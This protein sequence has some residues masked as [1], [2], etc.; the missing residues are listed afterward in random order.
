M[1]VSHIWLYSEKIKIQDWR[2]NICEVFARKP[3]FRPSAS[4]YDAI[5]KGLQ[6]GRYSCPEQRSTNAINLVGQSFY[7]MTCWPFNY[8]SNRDATL[9]SLCK[10]ATNKISQQFFEFLYW[11]GDTQYTPFTG[12]TTTKRKKQVA[13]LS[14][15]ESKQ[16]DIMMTGYRWQ[17]MVQRLITVWIKKCILAFIA[18]PNTLLNSTDVDPKCSFQPLIMLPIIWSQIHS[19]S[20]TGN[21]KFNCRRDSSLDQQYRKN[22]DM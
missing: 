19:G 17:K 5:C 15:K 3:L 20:Q 6:T 7:P 8:C 18:Y 2:W 14:R 16:T 13:K 11:D 9:Q 4:Y 22:S 1:Q 10:S 21:S 12:I